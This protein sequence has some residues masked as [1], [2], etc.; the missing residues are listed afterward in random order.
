[1]NMEIIYRPLYTLHK[2]EDN[3]R[4]ITPEQLSKLKESIQRNPDYFEARP[5]ILSDRTG[6]LVIIAG[7]QRYD[8]CAALGMESAPTVLIPN[9]TE[10]RER[11]II[12]R[13]NV[14][15]GQWDVNK[16]L[17]W[18]C[19]E[20]LDWGIEGLNFPEPTDFEDDKNLMGGGKMLKSESYEA[21][22]S[23]KY[24]AFEGYRIPITDQE[25]ENLKTKAKEYMEEN[26]VMIGFINYLLN[27]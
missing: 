16:L 1:M 25:L 11:E 8:A 19:N 5:L 14:N 27:S 9:L 17:D 4:S 12:I 26:G 3:P 7:N 10:E 20:L 6:E 23:I 21:G 24:L 2:L 22:A 18:D 13:D 15:N